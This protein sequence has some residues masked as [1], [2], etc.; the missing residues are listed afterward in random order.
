MFQ[1]VAY[2]LTNTCMLKTCGTDNEDIITINV[3][4]ACHDIHNHLLRYAY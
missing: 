3:N 1:V 4:M 2:E